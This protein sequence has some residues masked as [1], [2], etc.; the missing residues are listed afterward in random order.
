LAG[1]KPVK[2]GRPNEGG[3][4]S[5]GKGKGR[6]FEEDLHRSSQSGEAA[7]TS[8]ADSHKEATPIVLILVLLLVLEY[9]DDDEY[10]NEARIVATEVNT[11]G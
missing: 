6:K 7:T 11:D 1:S 10:E 3:N 9:E 4:A 8:H 5:K 2:A